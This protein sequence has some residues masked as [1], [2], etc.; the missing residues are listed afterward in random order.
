MQ[1]IHMALLAFAASAVAVD[2]STNPFYNVPTCAVC[3]QMSHI[4]SKNTNNHQQSCAKNLP[5]A[6]NGDATC[7]C[8]N[9]TWMW[10]VE[11][12]VAQ[13][14]GASDQVVTFQF[15]NQLCSYV[16]V[17]ITSPPTCSAVKSLPASTTLKTTS[18]TTS[19]TSAAPTGNPT[20][21][22]GYVAKGCYGEA[23][24]GGSNRALNKAS[25]SDPAGM[26]VES[27]VNFCKVRGW[28]YAGLEY[29][30]E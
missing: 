29:S 30:Q 6:C 11:C 21:Y 15:A 19:A 3:I 10:D 23:I 24:N 8:K 5:A 25:E 28:A 1:L 2:T 12:C 13:Q 4:E 22:A 26:T 27:C 17:S 9:Q 7:I 18:K 14:C 16:K 20:A